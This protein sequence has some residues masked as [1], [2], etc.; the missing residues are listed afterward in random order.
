M[1]PLHEQFPRLETTLPH[2][3]LG[4]FPTPVHPLAGLCSRLN[5]SDLYIKR[6]D[7]SATPYG[8]NNIRKLEFLLA[9]ARKKGAV[10]IITSGAAGSNH[11]LATAIFSR[12]YGFDCTLML[13]AQP[14]GH[15][16]SRQ[17]LADFATGAELLHDAT[18]TAHC[19]HLSEVVN[20]YTEADGVPPYVI[21]AGGSSATGVAGYVNAAFELAAQ[22]RHGEIPEPAAIYITLGTMGTVAGLLLGLAAAGIHS[23][24]AAVRVVPETVADHRKLALLFEESTT[25]LH[26]ADPDFPLLPF[27]QTFLDLKYDYLGDGYG[28]TTPST[29]A[30]IATFR[31][32]ESLTLDHVYTG[33]TA[34]A[35]LDD[36][37]TDRLL[38]KPVLFWH[39][40]SAHAAPVPEPPPDYRN[41]PPELHPYFSA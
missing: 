3:P 11:A 10:R 9:D 20:R 1:I 25:L 31:E 16:I 27:G 38:Q 14:P 35:F 30:A 39:T 36:I 26:S 37:A 4:T 6:D 41:L 29:D 5:R 24:V 21:P 15:G 2:L 40:K 17:L 22:I 8:G 19:R 12:K 33:K 7:L 13:F 28:I 18:Y 23:T 34:A 32:T